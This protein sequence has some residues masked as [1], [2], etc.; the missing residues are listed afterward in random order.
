MIKWLQNSPSVGTIYSINYQHKVQ[1]RALR[2]LH[3]L[4]FTTYQTKQED[5]DNIIFPQQW[6]LKL[7]FMVTQKRSDGEVIDINTIYAPGEDE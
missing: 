3:N 6:L 5:I 7:D 4:R 1:F 2:A